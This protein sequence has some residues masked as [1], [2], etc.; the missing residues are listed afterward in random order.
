MENYFRLYHLLSIPSIK[1]EHVQWIIE[2]SD[3]LNNINQ[4]HFIHQFSRQFPRFSSFES[5]IQSKTIPLVIENF[6]RKNGTILTIFDDNYPTFLK[7]IYQPPLILFARGKIEYLFE[8][9]LCA[10]VGSRT[11][12]EYSNKVLDLIIPGLVKND[13]VTVSGL[14]QGVDYLVHHKTVEE[15]GKTI[16]V[17]GGGFHHIYPNCNK[18]FANILMENQLVLSE[19]LPNIIP[20]K[21]HFPARNRIISGLSK[22]TIVIEAK[23]RS[24][25]L[26]TANLALQE[27]RNVLAV[28]GDIFNPL[29][30]GCNELIAAGA[31]P[32]NKIEDILEEVM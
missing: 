12:T 2:H 9:K 25:S 15:K 18:N 32:I 6:L 24:G 5:Y 7:E 3:Q 30:E 31:R 8:D 20:Q 29:S 11:P 14:A 21:W 4:P 28:P 27:G 10:I 22:A 17:I 26:I 19:Y 23:K 1:F 16:A 13:I